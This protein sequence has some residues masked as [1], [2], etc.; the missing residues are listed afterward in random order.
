[1]PHLFKFELTV[2]RADVVRVV[3]VDAV[4]AFWRL[5]AVRRQLLSH[6][7]RFL[8]DEREALW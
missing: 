3:G 1:M 8:E 2:G 5:V 7:R 6:F 4:R